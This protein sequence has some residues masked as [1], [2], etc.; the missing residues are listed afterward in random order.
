M[1]AQTADPG[2]ERERGKTASSSFLCPCILIVCS[3]K[4]LICFLTIVLASFNGI[5]GN[6][7]E[8]RSV[9]KMLNS[10]CCLNYII[11]LAV[12]TSYKFISPRLIKTSVK[13]AVVLVIARLGSGGSGSIH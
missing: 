7:A 6:V 1:D 4:P 3:F 12:I 5:S 2:S 10:G 13:M 11:Y 8:R 9:K